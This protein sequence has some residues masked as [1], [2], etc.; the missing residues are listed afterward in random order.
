MTFSGSTGVNQSHLEVNGHSQYLRDPATPSSYWN[1]VR[2]MPACDPNVL[3]WGGQSLGI[4]A[5]SDVSE[6]ATATSIS[7]EGTDFYA[8]G[9]KLFGAE[10]SI[11]LPVPGYMD[12]MQQ[13]YC[14]QMEGS[15]DELWDSIVQDFGFRG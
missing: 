3:T 4:S 1:G 5:Q 9:Q 6:T 2:Q 15:P 10:P 14:P 8:L 13:P 12:E 7:A 11:L